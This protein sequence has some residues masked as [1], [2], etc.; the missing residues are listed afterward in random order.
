M[1]HSTVP[2]NSTLE[3]HA[4]GIL[5]QDGDYQNDAT[6]TVESLRQ[7]HTSANVDGVTLP[8]TLTY[9]VGSDGDYSAT[10][11]ADNG[12]VAGRWYLA[13]IKVVAT[14]GLEREYTEDILV[15]RGSA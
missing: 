7:R 6:V 2:R 3:V 10:I 9:V 15:T 12:L 11:G 14:G 5:N 4:K 8:I 13:V 1:S